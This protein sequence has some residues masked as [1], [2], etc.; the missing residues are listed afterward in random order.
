VARRMLSLV[1]MVS[2]I[3][4]AYFIIPVENQ[5]QRDIVWR[6]VVAL[7]ALGLLAAGMIRL[8]QVHAEDNER[9]IEGLILGIVV[10]VVFFSFGY[11]LLARHNPHQVAGLHTRI[12]ALY[13]AV[14]T[15][16]TIGFGDVH[17]SGQV[18]RVL[19][20]VQVVFDLVFITA[21]ARLVTAHVR[22]VRETRETQQR[23]PR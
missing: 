14:T 21:A 4:L 11:Y 9:R 22:Q 3:L 18:A 15:L 5:A 6:A 8:L 19:V 2:L 10:V 1:G 12:D 13:F 7:L 16:S 23:N 20:M 17:A